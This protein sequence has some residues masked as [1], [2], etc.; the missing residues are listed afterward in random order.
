MSGN[1]SVDDMAATV[2][3]QPRSFGC[4][5][6]GKPIEVDSVL[7]A[8]SGADLARALRAKRKRNLTSEAAAE[9]GRKSAVKRRK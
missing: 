7:D 4:P 1:T 3:I 6:C 8:L 5:H 2:T 9:M